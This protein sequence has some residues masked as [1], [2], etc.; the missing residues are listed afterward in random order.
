LK[1]SFFK[2]IVLKI[3]HIINGLSN[4]GTEGVLYRLIAADQ[5]NEHYVISLTNFGVYGDRLLEIGI[6]VYQI[7]LSKNL[8]ILMQLLLIYRIT[9]K[10][11]PDL[12]QTW[13]YHSDLIGGIISKLLKVNAIVWGIRNS[14]LDKGK[15]PSSTRMI[16]KIN[17]FFSGFI[18]NKIISCSIFASKIHKNLG[19]D[20]EKMIVIPNG[21]NLDKFKPKNESRLALRDTLNVGGNFFLMG[22]VA[23]WHKHK[24]HKNLFEALSLLDK[25]STKQWKMIIIGHDID[26]SNIELIA[27]LNFFNLLH[28]VIILEQRTDIEVVYNALDLHILSSSGEAFPNV[29]AEAMSSEVPCVATNAGDSS[30]IIGETGWLASPKDP[31]DLERAL[32]LAI[33]EFFFDKPAWNNRKSNCRRRICDNFSLDRMVNDYQDVWSDV[34]H[35]E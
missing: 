1:I 17:G 33:N 25:T 30:L 18:P 10:I 7:N 29:I 26:D 27:L 34:F 2:G 19:Y 11:N 6:S 14:N 15:V 8:K 21:Y 35:N 3:L 5:I 12:V 28:K 24:D 4:G 20:N 9:K 13:M 23:R 22:M 16:A 32:S 31:S